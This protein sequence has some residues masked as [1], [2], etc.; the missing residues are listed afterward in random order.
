MS[1]CEGKIMDEAQ[2]T[3]RIEMVKGYYQRCFVF[4]FYVVDVLILSKV[5]VSA[6]YLPT[7]VWNTAST[8]NQVF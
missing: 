5:N 6:R 3:G 2:T 4:L 7:I 1:G 8:P